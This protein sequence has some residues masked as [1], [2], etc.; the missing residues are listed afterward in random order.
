MWHIFFITLFLYYGLY[1]V[2]LKPCFFNLRL[3]ILFLFSKPI[4]I[5]NLHSEGFFGLNLSLLHICNL[6]LTSWAFKLGDAFLYCSWYERLWEPAM[7]LTSWC[8]GSSS[9]QA[10]ARRQVPVPQPARETRVG[11]CSW[12][13]FCVSRTLF[14]ASS[15][16]IWMYAPHIGHHL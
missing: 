6:F 3:Y 15:G 16:F 5:Y 2:I 4:Y 13:C 9:L 1:F 7:Q 14:K 12:L 10:A 8:P 11:S